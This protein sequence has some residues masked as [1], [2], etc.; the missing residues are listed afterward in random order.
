MTAGTAPSVVVAVP[1]HDE[2]ALVASCLRSVA[3]AAE[4]AVEEGAIARAEIVLVAHRCRDETATVARHALATRRG[5]HRV[6]SSVIAWDEPADVGAVRDHAV[7]HGLRAVS[8]SAPDTWVFSTDA[9]T[10]VARDWMVRA[11]GEARRDDAVAVVGMVTIDSW[12]GSRSGLRRYR[13]LIE[14]GL[15]TDE[16]G[17]PAHRHVYGANLAVR[18]DAYLAVGG[19]PANGHG[20]DQHLVDALAAAGHRMVRT[21]DVVTTTSGRTTGR[22]GGGLAHLLRRLGQ[23]PAPALDRLGRAAELGEHV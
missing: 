16:Q 7:R 15:Y 11:L 14:R 20:E 23:D 6:T 12:R 19:F 21:R 9:D 13:E 10:V 3:A 1:A 22:A 18:A 8:G 2:A 4:A 17:R 5:S